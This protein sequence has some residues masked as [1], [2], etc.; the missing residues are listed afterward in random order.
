MAI[1]DSIV[2]LGIIAA[3]VPFVLFSL[4]ARRLRLKQELPFREDLR[5]S[6]VR[7]LGALP[8]P[9]LRRRL[10][11]PPMETIINSNRF[12]ASKEHLGLRVNHGLC[13]GYWICRGPPGLPKQPRESDIVLLWFHGGAYC[14]SGPSAPALSLLRV[15]E[16]A[17]SRGLSMSI[18]SAGY[19]LAPEATFPHQQREAVAA[20][21]Y[22]LE[23]EEVHENKIIIAGDSA[24]GHLSLACLIAL[25]DG[26][27]PKPARALLLYP[28]TN[29]ENRKLSFKPN[30]DKDI[31]SKG[32]LDRCVRA[33]M[34]GRARVEELEFGNLTKP[35]TISDQKSW[36]HIL[37]STWVSVGA[38][39]LFL[40][41]IRM[42]VEQAQADGAQ[43]KLDVTPGRA[44]SWNF[45][46]DRPSESAY[47]NLDPNDAVLVGMMDGSNNLAEGLFTLLGIPQA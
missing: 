18:F 16:I 8:L 12:R 36:K 21:R 13:T 31:L 25:A 41:D 5:R 1:Q 9:V 27:L 33:T 4:F 47:C 23:V 45:F 11:P 14:F 43:V 17:A 34:G 20:Y 29:M 40:H 37:P 32:L 35:W 46:L 19:T 22:L 39:D 10:E 42:F 30:R 15:A 2:S 26:S 6:M 24:G 28:W 7:G 3:T 38:H 44:H